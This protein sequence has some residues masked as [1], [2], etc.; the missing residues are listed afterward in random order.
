MV[1]S[2]EDEYESEPQELTTLLLATNHHL[3]TWSRGLESNKS[4]KILRYLICQMWDVTGGEIPTAQITLTQESLSRELGIN[5]KWVNVLCKR[6]VKAEWVEYDG[7]DVW[8]AGPMLKRVVTLL[9]KGVHAHHSNEHWD[10][11]FQELEGETPCEICHARKEND[12]E[13][14]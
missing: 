8:R 7:S 10:K 1:T 3:S 13:I 5:K 2:S 6:L 9:N 11:A 4:W 14:P 12:S